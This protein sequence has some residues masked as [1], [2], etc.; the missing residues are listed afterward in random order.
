LKVGFRFL[1]LAKSAAVVSPNCE[2]IKIKKHFDEK[3]EIDSLKGKRYEKKK[4][5]INW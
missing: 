5:N 1:A 2:K 4:L 3:L